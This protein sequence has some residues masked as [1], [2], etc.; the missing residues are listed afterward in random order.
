VLK[1]DKVLKVP[2][3]QHQV[4]LDRK[5]HKDFKEIRGLKD[6]KVL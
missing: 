5:V 2:Q 3:I 1:G 6:F 4:L